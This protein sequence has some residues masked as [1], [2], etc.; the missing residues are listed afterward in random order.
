MIWPLLIPIYPV[1]IRQTIKLQI[2]GKTPDANWRCKLFY[3]SGS[4]FKMIT[5]NVMFEILQCEAYSDIKLYQYLPD[6]SVNEAYTNHS[7]G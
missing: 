3:Q 1:K 2:L 7:M 4:K 5:V 6:T